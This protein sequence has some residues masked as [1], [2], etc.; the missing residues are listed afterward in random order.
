MMLKPFQICRFFAVIPLATV[1]AVLLLGPVPIQAQAES[2]ADPAAA[3][4]AALS[5]A[6]RADQ[7]QFEKYLTVDSA[8]ALR[9][10]PADQ[11]AAFLKRFSLSEEAGKALVTSGPQNHPVV[12]CQAPGG[13]AEFRFGD[14]R[15]HDNL[16][17]IR[18]DVVDSEQ[19]NFGLIRED[20]VWRLLSLGLVMLD[21]P[22]LSRE[23]AEADL[24]SHEDAVVS[25]LSA[26]AGA[27]ESY[28][29]A[30]DKLPDSLAQL[31]PAPKGEISPEQA[32]LVD[33][34]LAAGDAGG[35]HFRYRIASS[36]NAD[37]PE[38]DGF[39]LS[40]TPNDYGKAGKRSFFLDAAGKIHGDDKH[41]EI[42]SASDPL[43][44]PAAQPPDSGSAAAV[45]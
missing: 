13:T 25:T 10:L 6:C 16:A 45:Q 21:V 2:A 34:H 30:F 7:A 12:R 17:F 43:V 33:E 19:T 1:L 24:A 37:T 27:V 23:W 39:E 9:G 8:A 14:E 22:Q 40:A 18:V 42:A 35:Y 32:D 3:L 4:S 28:R 31:G 15:V 38:G 5:A 44:A 29:R 20:G 41:G 36:P 11:R 26:L